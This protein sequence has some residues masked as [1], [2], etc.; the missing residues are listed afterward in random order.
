MRNGKGG[1]H[2]DGGY[3]HSDC[4]GDQSG[5]HGGGG[6]RGGGG[7]GGGSHGGGGRGGCHRDGHGDSGSGSRLMRSYGVNGGG[8]SSRDEV[9]I[10]GQVSL[11]YGGREKVDEVT[12]SRPSQRRKIPVVNARKVW[13]TLKPSTCST[14]A[15][16]FKKLI[17]Q[18]LADRLT[19]KRKYTTNCNGSV[20]RWWYVGRG[21]ELDLAE[22]EKAWEAIATQTGWKLEPLFRFDNSDKTTSPTFL[23]YFRKAFD[24][25]PH[26]LLVDKLTSLGLDAHIISWITSYLTNWK[27]HVVVGRESSQDAPV[28]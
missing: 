15:T 20:Q 18:S 19:V 28:L 5:G 24:S 13:G 25:V 26:Q 23:F 7:H 27:Q 22:L 1:F 12:R 9:D 4:S 14:V 2:R 11:G 17:S 3:G 10:S 6:H 8:Q 21:E 16:V